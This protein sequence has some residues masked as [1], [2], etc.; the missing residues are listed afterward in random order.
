[1]KV[2]MLILASDGGKDDLYT[3]LQ[4]VKRLYVHSYP[5]V[6]AYFYKA[7][8]NLET[9]HKIIGDIIYVKTEETYPELWK[10]LLLI[11]KVFENKLDNYD[12]ISRPN[13]STFFIM[14][15]YL[16]HLQSLPKQMCCSGLQFYGRQPIPF[17]SGYLFTITPDIAHYII[18]NNIIL[19]NIGIDDRCVGVI[20]KE[21]KIGITQFPFIEIE[22]PYIYETDILKC[23]LEDP[24]IF[25]IRIRHFLNYNTLFG[26]DIDNRAEKDLFIH[27][28]LLK[29]FYGYTDE[30][31]LTE[32]NIDMLK[33]PSNIVV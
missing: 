16:N 6:D 26:A 4:K 33:C 29:K 22:N 19:N 31:I 24:N 8:P 28:L 7:D 11:L 14:D 30:V 15:R 25:L 10:K 21:L 20:L 23:R 5:E 12:F 18:N 1:M 13:L 9:D 17:P 3:K 32:L 2:L 27:C